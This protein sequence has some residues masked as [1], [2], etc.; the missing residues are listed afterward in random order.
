MSADLKQSV[1]PA[2]TRLI[3][4]LKPYAVFVIMAPL[5]MA[6]EVFMDL[7]QPAFMA[8]VVND[9]IL[10]GDMGVITYT[11]LK[12]LAAAVIGMVGGFGCTVFAMLASQNYAADLR[13][14]LFRKVESFSFDEIDKFSTGSLVTRLTNDV[15]Q[16]ENLVGM[17]LRMFV[18]APLLCIGGIYMALSISA[19]F[20]VVLMVCLPVMVVLV[21]LIFRKIMPIFQSMQKKIDKLNA[22]LQ[23]NLSGVRVIKAF[24]RGD[25]E[26]K[27][28]NEAN[29]D[30]TRTALSAMNIMA[31]GMPLMMIMM[32][33]VVIAVI[34]IGGYQ[35]QAA[36]LRVGDVMAAISY[37]T[38]ILMSFMMMSMVFMMIPRAKASGD[39]VREVLE[40]RLSIAGGDY[41]E[42]I[43]HGDI[44]FEDVSFTYAGGSEE[45]VLKNISLRAGAGEH[46]GLLGATGAGKSTLVHLIPRFYDA[47]SGR[48]LIDGV[49]VREYSL[50]ALRSQIGFVLQESVLFSGTVAENIRWGGPDAA[51]EAVVQA[52]EAAQADEYISEMSDGYDSVIGQRGLTLSGGQK[53]RA[54]IARAL[55]KQPKILILDDSTSALDLGTENR[56]NAAINAGYTNGTR[57][58]IAQRISSVMNADRI[59]VIDDGAIAAEGSHSELLAGSAIYRDIFE[60]QMGQGALA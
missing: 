58:T 41:Q 10:G 36:E 37:M 35:V 49:D 38:Q 22:I 33:A 4:Y 42:E 28:F 34:Y 17:A 45:P 9:G 18:R 11:C 8:I 51:E 3:N 48:I 5:M 57:I 52:A 16:L 46:I 7:Q 59:Y 12:M 56:L 43:I 53:Q 30:L 23:E 25:F 29:E 20:G 24:V 2:K 15:T 1:P 19:Q 47:T 27:R 21:V 26:K 6:L 54:C 31:V 50:P 39:R 32:N 13:S 14:G 44:V 60:S 55:L 40:T